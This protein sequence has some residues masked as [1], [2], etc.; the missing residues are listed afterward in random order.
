[1]K[2]TLGSL[3]LD[4]GWAFE[5][6]WDG[7]RILAHVGTGGVRLQSTGGH[8]TTDRWP[9]LA[10]LGAAVNAESAIIDGELVVLDDDGLPRFELIQQRGME[11]REAVLH[12]FD[13]LSVNA[14]DTIALPYEDRRHLLEQLVE[15]GDNWLVPAHRVGDGETLLAATNEQGLEGVV[16]KRLDSTY[17]PGTRTRDWLK[18]KNR[19]R[20]D[21]T[22]GGY[23]DGTGAREST[24]G[25]LLVGRPGDRTLRFAGGVGT[26]FTQSTLVDLSRRLYAI[27]TEECPFEPPPPSQYRRGATWVRPELTAT[28]E[29]AEFTNDGFVRHASYIE[30]REG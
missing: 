5:V 13:V 1:M 4:Q 19:Q 11:R 14:T 2:A 7:Y 29:I 28:I 20:V 10:A 18:V 30:F 21:V 26:G 16:A 17:R 12:V 8:D 15:D 27:R 25:A 23:T 6:K 9:E 22:I 24:F 3:P